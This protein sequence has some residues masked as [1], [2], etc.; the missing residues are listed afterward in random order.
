MATTALATTPPVQASIAPQ[1]MK[2]GNDTVTQNVA[3]PLTT[4][5]PNSAYTVT[6]G[7]LPVS[8]TTLSNS[9][10]QSQ[11]GNI[12]NTTN[13]LAK[14]GST[15]NADGSVT[16][17]D[18]TLTPPPA[19]TTSTTPPKTQ[20]TSTGGYVGDMYYAPGATLPTDANGQPT[21]TTTTSP[22][23]DQ[24]MNSLQQQKIQTDAMT[25]SLISNIQSQYDQLIKQQQTTNAGQEGNV[26]AALSM[27][28]V[29]GGGG[30]SQYAPISS[31]GIIQAQVSYGTQQIADLQSKEQSAILQAQQ[32]G[33]NADFQLQNQI[34]KQIS[35]IRDQKV[36]AAISLNNT[37]ATQA[38]KMADDKLQ[39]TKDTAVANLFTSGVT[40]PAKIL[41]TLKG[42]GLTI[43]ASEISNALKDINP[44]KA[45]INTIV[46][47]AIKAGATPEMIKQIQEATDSTQALSIAT[48][49]LSAQ[50]QTEL[51]S[52]LFTPPT[53]KILGEAQFYKYPSSSIVYSSKGVPLSLQQYKDAT[54][55]NN[56]PD[57]KVSFNGIKTINPTSSTSAP[58][59][60]KAPPLSDDVKSMDSQLSSVSGEDGYISQEDYKKAKNAWVGSGRSSASFDTNFKNRINP[61]YAKDYK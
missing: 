34:N 28:G 11:V 25:A 16:H 54:G 58:S 38:K 60:T 33:Q 3:G 47:N 13:T 20:L 26:N 36:N 22:T 61:L 39:Q 46:E 29:T 42:Q 30:S 2:F 5:A 9:N 4:S 57:D 41:E 19:E 35:D 12:Q 56:T 8:T 43:N 31:A 10:K 7:E 44:D 59:K 53:A 40:D 51:N 21:Q 50:A 24:I 15:Y 48:P 55:Q 52:K 23:D 17:A 37:L 14:T 18:G 1:V 27:G 32:A 45:A 49:T 6:S